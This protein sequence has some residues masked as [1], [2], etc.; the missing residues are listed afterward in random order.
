MVTH[1][2]QFAD[3]S[4]W[5]PDGITRA[6]KRENDSFSLSTQYHIFVGGQCGIMYMVK[7]LS[8]HKNVKEVAY[9]TL[10]HQVSISDNFV[11]FKKEQF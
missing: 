9:M 10:G 7:L 4:F 5:V 2:R 1:C 3:L 8:T 6:Y 11:I